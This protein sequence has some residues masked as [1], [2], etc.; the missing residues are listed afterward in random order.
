MMTYLF[1]FV[2]SATR[3]EWWLTTLATAA[4]EG[5]LRLC[6]PLPVLCAAVSVLLLLPWLA[7]SSRRLRSS[8]NA[9]ETGVFCFA[10]LPTLAFLLPLLGEHTREVAEPL[11]QVFMLIC[12]IVFLSYAI[13]CGCITGKK[14]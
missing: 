8:G 5:L 10:L 13:I 2:G 7:V 11:V 3:K 12:G 4:A 9:P 14:A 1:R 6:C